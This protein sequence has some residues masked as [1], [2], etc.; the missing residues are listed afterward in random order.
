MFIR[1]RLK[2]KSMISL[3]GFV[4][5]I[6]TSSANAELKSTESV[7]WYQMS[8]D[9]FVKLPEVNDSVNWQYPNYPLLEAAIFQCTNEER[10]KMEI[11][12]LNYSVALNKSSTYHSVAMAK[13][14]FFSHENNYQ[15]TMRTFDQRMIHYGAHYHSYGENIAY[16]EFD[17]C[18][19]LDIARNIVSLWM[20]SEGHR[21][22]ILNSDYSELGCGVQ[23][24][25][26]KYWKR[27]YAT[28]DFGG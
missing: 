11:T 26:M 8:Y 1:F 25:Q 5:L 3:I 22:N 4:S 14:K 18:T 23:I 28:Q 12:P 20:N 13:Y 15:K 27:V 19:Y 7:S 24:S 17:S 2:S 9:S 6:T 21:H 10:M 16:S